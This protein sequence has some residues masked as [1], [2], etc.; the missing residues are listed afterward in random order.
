MFL[1][2]KKEVHKLQKQCFAERVAFPIIMDNMLRDRRFYVWQF[3][4]TNESCTSPY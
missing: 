2:A 1:Y 4:L 3:L